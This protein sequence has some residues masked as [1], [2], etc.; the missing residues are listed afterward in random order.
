MYGDLIILNNDQDGDSSLIAV[1]KATGKIAWQTP[2]KSKRLTYST[3]IPYKAFGRDEELIF[4]NW[5]HGITGI[6]PKNR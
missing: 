1:H 4:T 3:P 6:D 2:R 5:T